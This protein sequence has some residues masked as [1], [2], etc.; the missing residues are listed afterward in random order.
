M[1]ALHEDW[2][3]TP[4][5]VAHVLDRLPDYRQTG[6]TQWTAVCPAHNDKSP[7]L[8]VS[9]GDSQP[10]VLWCHAGCETVE[11]ILPAL[12]AL[13]VDADVLRGKRAVLN[14]RKRGRRATSPLRAVPDVPA[15]PPVLNDVGDTW[16]DWHDR[17]KDRA[18]NPDSVEADMLGFLTSQRGLTEETLARYKIGFDGERLTIPIKLRGK[19]RNVRRYKP[20]SSK[21]KM[22]SWKGYSSSMLYPAQVLQ[23]APGTVPVLF[24]EGE[25]DALLANQQS[26]GQYVAVTGTG[27]ASVP[28]KDLSAL[29]GRRVFIA[30][31][32][33][34]A[35]AKGAAKLA[36]RLRSAGATPHV[37]DLTALGLESGSGEDITDYF[38]RYGGTAGRLTEETDRVGQEA[39]ADGRDAVLEAVEALFLA[40]DDQRLDYVEDGLSDGQVL[41]LDPPQFVIDGWVPQG[42]YSVLYGEPG[43]KKTFALLDMAK[44]IRRGTKWQGQPVQHGAVLF[45]QGEGLQQL[46]P[47]IQAWD[48][49]NTDG[50]DTPGLYFGRNIDLTLPRGA[51][52][53]VRTVERF[54][55]EQQCKVVAVVIDPL[56]EFMTGEEN[57]EGMELVTRGLRA[58]AQY[59]DIAV[60]VGHHT[61]AAGGRARGGDWLRMRAGAHIRAEPLNGGQT[62]LVQE[63]QKNAEKLALVLDPVLVG[64]SLVLQKSAGMTAVQYAAQK[65]ATEGTERAHAKAKLSTVQGSVKRRRAEELLVAYVR[66]HPGATQNKILGGTTG[67]NIGKPILES[68]LADLCGKDGP[69]RVERRGASRNS[70]QNFWVRE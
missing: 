62:G 25:W 2:P 34:A 65:E 19:L 63:K 55:R 10:V 23:E 41:A 61:N 51:A 67:N 43:A 18:Q 9:V 16:L 31:D 32:A 70:P 50:S 22:I 40:G 8:S 24:C 53:V 17:L 20:G 7:S 33:D 68:V 52:G 46:T 29:N 38:T 30:Y 45:F 42:F 27:G 15:E 48:R 49:F 56:V 14:L 3:E 36:D 58:V 54:Q 13:G 26:E 59:L 37:L 11:D 6:P 5:A 66:E 21:S 64:D 60:I 69:L 57:G 28:P 39:P 47:R 35:G 44:S 12:E 1:R 4:D